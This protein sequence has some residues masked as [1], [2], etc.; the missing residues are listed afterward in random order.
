MKLFVCLVIAVAFVTTTV[1]LWP[2]SFGIFSSDALAMFWWPLSP[3]LMIALLLW[4]SRSKAALTALLVVCLLTSVLGAALIL[5]LVYMHCRCVQRA[6][7]DD[8]AAGAMGRV[9]CARPDTAYLVEQSQECVR[10]S[11][12]PSQA[13][14]A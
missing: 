14:S 1:A 12:E 11:R 8:G 9:A 13:Q 4:G 7:R 3:Y 2:T 6:D 10:H 5:D